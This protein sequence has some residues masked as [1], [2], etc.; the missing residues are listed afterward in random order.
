MCVLHVGS[1]WLLFLLHAGPYFSSITPTNQLYYAWNAVSCDPGGQSSSHQFIYSN[2]DYIQPLFSFMISASEG[3]R[4]DQLRTLKVQESCNFLGIEEVAGIQDLKFLYFYS[5][6][7]AIFS[8]HCYLSWSGQLK[9]LKGRKSVLDPK[10]VL[11][12]G[13]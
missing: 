7:C 4:E 6:H 11:L 9:A 3:A 5:F 8:S 1:Y 2:L 10:V 12:W 13:V